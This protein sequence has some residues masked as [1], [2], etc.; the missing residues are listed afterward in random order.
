MPPAARRLVL[1]QLL[2]AGLLLGLLLYRLWPLQPLCRGLVVGGPAPDYEAA[3]S[4]PD[5][6]EQPAEPFPELQRARL[7]AR[8]GV[9]RWHKA[10]HR[11]QGVK[12]AVLD[13]GFR[14]YRAHL[15]EALPARVT[16]RSFRLDGNLEA[17]DSQHGI[18]C[19]EV[20]H[21][22][23]P[24]ADILLANW[25]PDRPEQ[26]LAAVR[27]ARQQ[28]ARLI[29][30]SVI[31]PSWSDGEGNG[32]VHEE[33]TKLL[34]PGT[35]AGDLL[36]FASAGNTAQRHW[37]G[38]FHDGGRGWHE[39]HDGE[40][41]NRITP[42]GTERLSVE[43]CWRP[44]PEYQLAVT[45]D[46]GREVGH[47][48]RCA[49]GPCC[50]VVRFDPEPRHTYTVRVRL[51]RGEPGTFHL[52][53]LGGG[54]GQS[55]ARGSI[56]FPGDGP[57][58]IAV[59]AVDGDGHRLGYS[60]CGPNSRR[61]KPDLVATVP[62]PSLWRARPFAGTS[63]AAPQAA[64]LAALLW[65]RCPRWTAQQVRAALQKSAHDLGEPGYDTE[66]GYGLVGLPEKATDE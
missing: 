65:S 35:A 40:I 13:S 42:W 7:L 52:V 33:M 26:F 24:A 18:L 11:G 29:S 43:L 51:V 23:A 61:P 21:A 44:G 25:E 45:E 12:V 56:S 48:G 14:G 6:G 66:T 5:C 59:G 15:G 2:C 20:I 34:G 60:S 10:G 58:V 28:G 38:A 54:L 30:C 64:A 19:G 47:S 46:D 62:F 50:A 53:A 9:D 17:R 49:A 41:D 36:C 1:P 55:T 31:M 8:L 16:V 63:A 4:T 22:L 57:E 27:W 3:G 37:A 32:A 39:W